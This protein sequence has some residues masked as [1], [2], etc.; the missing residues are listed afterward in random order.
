MLKKQGQRK[1]SCK[2]QISSYPK[3]ASIVIKLR[4]KQSFFKCPTPSQQKHFW[5]GV[6]PSLSLVTCLP[7]TC[8]WKSVFLPFRALLDHKNNFI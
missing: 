6:A 3:N 4:I 5:S 8:P 2:T 7:C 1:A